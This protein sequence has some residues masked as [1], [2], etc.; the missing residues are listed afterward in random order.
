MRPVLITGA[1]ALGQVVARLCDERGLARVVTTRRQ[2][3]LAS[4]YAADR[5]VE[6][7]RPWLVVNAAGYRRIDHA[8]R[9]PEGCYRDN[10]HGPELLARA[11]AHHA[12]PLITFSSDLVF[13]GCSAVPYVEHDALAPLGVFGR[14]K[15]VAERRIYAAYPGALVIRT[16][17]CFGPWDDANFI[18]AALRELAAGRDARVPRGLIVSPAYLPDVVH[19]ALDLAIDGERGCWHL[20]HPDAISV[21]EAVCRAAPARARV[22]EVEPEALGWR[23]RRPA[24]RALG[25]THGALLPPFDDAVQR[26]HQT[27]S[28]A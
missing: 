8:E 28:F 27:R 6:M 7:C 26:Y 17:A 22:T 24:Y 13:D 14:T 11:C 1:G 12:T 3:E 21:H 9:D 20:A 16:G 25:S 4:P 10:V 23:A 2:L 19:A 15:Q 5:M 18:T